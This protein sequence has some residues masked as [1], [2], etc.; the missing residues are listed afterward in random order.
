[1]TGPEQQ[2]AGAEQR[3]VGAEQ[4][5]GWV[6][7]PEQREQWWAESGQQEIPMSVHLWW[8][9]QQRAQGSLV[10]CCRR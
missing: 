9:R 8:E 7:R 1:M 4:Q 3:V 2:V 10:Q 6:A 5:E